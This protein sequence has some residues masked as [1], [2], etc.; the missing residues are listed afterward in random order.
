MLSAVPCWSLSMPWDTA[1]TSCNVAAN[2]V[3]SK[4][5]QVEMCTNT[6]LRVAA[7]IA[8]HTHSTHYGRQLLGNGAATWLHTKGYPHLEALNVYA[9]S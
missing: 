8:N 3:R 1:D 2:H 5:K 7:H 9:T 6:C 4:P